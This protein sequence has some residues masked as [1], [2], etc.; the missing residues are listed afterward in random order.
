MKITL[1]DSTV[2]TLDGAMSAFEAAK[3]ISEGLARAALACKIDGKLASMDETIDRDCA[4]EV[5]TFDSDEGKKVY[6]NE[7]NTVPGSLAYYL[8]KGVGISRGELLD[9]LIENASL[10][11][12]A[13]P[14]SLRTNILNN[15]GGGGK[16]EG[17]G[18]LSG[19][20]L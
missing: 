15:F 3:H 20:K 6:L 17:N 7:I 5:L 2:L 4:F 19:G 1:K 16:L 9:I 14:R 8:F 13:L 12:Y 10:K 18:K 11:E